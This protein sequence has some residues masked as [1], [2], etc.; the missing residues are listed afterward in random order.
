MD[1]NF[2]LKIKEIIA[3]SRE[4]ASRLGN[5]F[6]GV[7]HLFLGILRD[8]SNIVMA[9]LDTMNI[10]KQE[11]KLQVESFL[12]PLSVNNVNS[13]YSIPLT[14]QAEKV[15]RLALLESK[16]FQNDEVEP[17]HLMLSILKNKD[18]G[19]TQILEQLKITYKIFLEKSGLTSKVENGNE[20]TVSAYSQATDINFQSN[21]NP[22]V[23]SNTPVLNNFGKDISLMAENQQ[24]DPIVG[25]EK[26]IERV[27]QILS[28]RKKNNPILIGEPGVGKTAIV[29]GLAIQI[30]EKKLSR[31]LQNKRIIS[32]DLASLVAGTKYRGQFEERI[33]AVLNELEKN[34]NIILFID[35]IHTIIGAGGATGSLDA[36]NILKPSLA[37][38]EIQ[39]I[40]A[41]TLEEYKKYIETDGALDRRFQRVLVEEPSIDE[42][43]QILQN[44]K[45]KYE[46]FHLVTYTDVAIQACVKLSD[47][48]MKD[49]LLPDKAIDLMDEVGARSHLQNI[50]LPQE[51]IQLEND[52]LAV[53]KEQ[54]QY[55]SKQMFE[56]AIKLRDKKDNME[57]ALCHVK[58]EWQKENQQKKVLI[59][60]ED[61]AQI[62]HQITNISIGK[63]LEEE[64]EYLRNIES[65][66]KEN[67]IGQEEAV[68]KIS[69]SIQRNRL[70]LNSNKRPIGAFIFLGSTGVGKTQLAKLLAK[71]LFNDEGAMVRIDMSEYMEK[72]A[73][74]RLIGSPP[75]YVGYEEGGQLTEKIRR[76][77][78]SLILLDEIEKA[79]SDIFNILLQ[80]LDEGQLTDGLG[81]KVDFKNTLIIMT[82]NIGTKQISE[83]GNGVGFTT[84]T[85]ERNSDEFKKAVI[86]KSL[87]RTFTPEF[88][89]RLDD[90][91]F[92][93]SLSKGHIVKIIDLLLETTIERI[94]KLGYEL[95]VSEEAKQ[96]I[97][98]KGYDESMGARPLQRTIQYYIDNNVAEAILYNNIREGDCLL[99]DVNEEKSDI[100]IQVIEK[101]S[102]S[103]KKNVKIKKC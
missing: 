14:R 68:S 92:F 101:S 40:G 98:D 71:Y 5:D 21:N 61:I 17:I 88:L 11:L 32:L 67:L 24:L 37:R 74:S 42:S 78:Y 39:C 99:A 26:E 96:F 93:N 90:V 12:P 15:L 95:Q 75:G 28:R 72:H 20:D 66:L 58:E 81:R 65:I 54:E 10:D 50:Y 8:N 18:N 23:N 45:L 79:H 84:K 31:I 1:A 97:A 35:E 36:A 76:K 73:V 80:V 63:M 55:V 6:M 13:N 7:E 19:V 47:R 22:H 2:S 44:I 9:I 38:G 16:Q 70:G 49:R 69:K 29:E 27:S 30:Y 102:K 3:Y 59:K 57:K 89:N 94:K 25:R 48:Y 56:E 46:D 64:T 87:K 33:K 53:K 43:I 103:V 82:S 4:E 85:K 60:E 91:I 77:P 86:E 52:I 34:K 41:T 51:I 100:K 83:F 62:V